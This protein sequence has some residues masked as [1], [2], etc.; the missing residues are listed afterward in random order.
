MYYKKLNLD[1]Y[2]YF[3]RSTHRGG[4]ALR[5]RGCPEGRFI[6]RVRFGRRPSRNKPHG[7]LILLKV[8]T[9][10]FGNHT[11]LYR[12]YPKALVGVLFKP[13]GHL[14]WVH[15]HEPR[16]YVRY[17]YPCKGLCLQDFRNALIRSRLQAILH[18]VARG[19]QVLKLARWQQLL[20][21]VLLATTPRLVV[22]C[23]R[24]G[25][26]RFELNSCRRT[27]I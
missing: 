26:S 1:S 22:K 11:L 23:S 14:V 4:R 3:W 19:Q 17:T 13:V 7:A 8:C 9:Y 24:P 20:S 12:L 5:V 25:C 2:V 15:A 16:T 27:I 6:S 10:V 21:S 18:V